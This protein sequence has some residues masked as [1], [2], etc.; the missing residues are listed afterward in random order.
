MEKVVKVYD[1]A[2]PHHLANVPIWNKIICVTFLAACYTVL[3]E[4]CGF[5]HN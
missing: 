1:C 4:L 5:I 3:P 2:G